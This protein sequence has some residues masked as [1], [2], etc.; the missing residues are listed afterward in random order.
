MAN[1]YLNDKVKVVR[2]RMKRE[3]FHFKDEFRLIPLWYKNLLW[4]LYALALV[5]FELINY[6]ARPMSP[7]VP[8]PLSALA[9]AGIVTGVWIGASCL[10]LLFCYIYYDAKRREMR[11]V[12]WL[13][14]AIFVPDLIGVILYFLLRDPLPYRCPQCGAEANPRFNFCPQCKY[15]LQEAPPACPQCKREVRPDHRYCPYC[16]RDLAPSPSGPV[17]SPAPGAPT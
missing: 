11:A 1:Q 2:W 7:D 6:F 12:A 8:F 3:P 15:D 4:V 10:L 17:T 16:G 9:M 5:V 14:L 13:L